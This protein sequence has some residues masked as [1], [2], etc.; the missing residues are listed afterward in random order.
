MEEPDQLPR[1]VAII[2]DGNGRWA[3]KR[4]L[5]RHRGHEEG[6]AAVREVVEEAAR[7]GLKQLTLYA[8]SAENLSRRP[9]DEVDFLMD[10]LKK[11]L[12]DEFPSILEN[13]IR[14]ASIGRVHQLRDDVKEELTKVTQ[15]SSGNAG[16]TLCLALNYGGRSEIAD[17]AKNLAD[18]A[19][20]GKLP[21]DRI[22]ES[23]FQSY[24]Y[25]AGMPDPDMII[26]TGG[27]LRMSNF[28][29]WQA[30]YSELWVTPILWPDFCK[31]HLHQAFRDYGTRVRRFGGLST[32]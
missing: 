10:L 2:M 12:R 15:G 25:T 9:P 29:L 32:G 17:A 27:E 13:R 31:E 7:Q 8:L 19:V 30:Y 14:F 5:P 11:S 24:L 22:D 6:A 16:M 20:K 26:R 1:H 3:R 21:V 4:G 18:D 28:L 23:V